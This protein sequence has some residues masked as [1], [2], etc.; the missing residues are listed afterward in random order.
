MSPPQTRVERL[1]DVEAAVRRVRW[2]GAAFAFAQV[3]F[4]YEPPAGTLMPFP[5]V[6]VALGLTATVVGLNLISMAVERSSSER[7]V[8][9]VGVVLNAADL[10]I[11]VWVIA[12]FAFDAESRLWPLL[13][14][15]ILEAGLREQIRGAVAIAVAGTVADALIF[16]D[17]YDAAELV[18]TSF[19]RGAILVILA[20]TI[21]GLAARFEE[22]RASA[23]DHA[24]RLQQLAELARDLPSHRRAEEVLHRV[25]EAARELTDVELCEVHT[26]DGTGW[27]LQAQSGDPTPSLLDRLLVGD[28]DGPDAT[29]VVSRSD[30]TSGLLAVPIDIRGEPTGLLILS[31]GPHETHGF[32]EQD[33]DVVQLLAN[34][35]GVAL[36]TARVIEELRAL[37]EVKDEFL[38]ILAHELRGPMTALTGYAELLKQ[39]WDRLDDDRRQEFL[40]AVERGTQRMAKLVRD[41]QDVSQADRRQLTVRTTTF[42]VLPVVER[43]AIEE[44]SR[45]PV[46]RLELDVPDAPVTVAADPDR[47]TQVLSNLI[48]NAVKYSPD[49]G[50]VHVAVASGAMYARIEVTDDG[51]G[52]PRHLR[53]HLFQKFSRLPTP[54][55]VEGTGLGLYLSRML[56]EA[57]GGTIAVDSEEGRGSTFRF[58]LPL[59]ERSEVVDV[60]SSDRE[61]PVTGPEA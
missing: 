3:G 7:T 25:L 49:G 31:R 45:S 9:L 46:H 16:L 37:D 22:A 6:A 38:H 50:R 47:L 54:E 59:A 12:L 15:P 52:I 44:V 60:T 40:D 11:V 24:D 57:M 48:S 28:G 34:H 39:R 58:T 21:G 43:T 10:L 17:Q 5:R 18:S 8:R 41:V 23:E 53:A 36:E 19:F 35:A 30:A 2:L 26:R 55:R 13:V 42:D 32:T 33:R 51:Y 14:L 27:T 1:H 56:V 61:D 20:V 4:L 29:A